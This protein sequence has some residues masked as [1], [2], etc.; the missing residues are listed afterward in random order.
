MKFKPTR[1]SIKRPK[2]LVV[3]IISLILA[4]G[5]IT[6]GIFSY[7]YWQEYANQGPKASAFLKSAISDSLGSDNTSS[8]PSAQIDTIV[9]KFEKD[10]GK[11]PCEVSALYSWQTVLPQLNDM[12]TTCNAGFTIATEVIKALKPLSQFLKD[13]KK[14]TDLLAA[15]LAATALPTDFTDAGNVWKTALESSE[16]PKS[17]EFKAVR[18]KASEVVLAI[19]TAYTAL[20][21]AVSNEDKGAFDK[22]LTDLATAYATI[23]QLKTTVND[24]RTKLI[25]ALIAAYEKL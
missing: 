18:A 3:L 16:L 6:Y 12:R 23:D 22:A 1:I 19:T 17:D 14:A 24:E 13:E 5:V 8:T 2:R 20:A 11:N 25:T 7:L 10:Y 15:T 4:L 21:T 9:T